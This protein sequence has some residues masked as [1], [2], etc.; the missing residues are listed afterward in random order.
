M[1]SA[2]A[3]V[4]I[5]TGAHQAARIDP[6]YFLS[7]KIAARNGFISSAQDND[8]PALAN[9][10]AIARVAEHYVGAMFKEHDPDSSDE[11]DPLSCQLAIRIDTVALDRPCG[12]CGQETVS[13]SYPS[14]K[15]GFPEM[16]INEAI[17]CDACGDRYA[18]AL[19]ALRDLAGEAERYAQHVPTPKELPYNKNP[20]MVAAIDSLSWTTCP[21]CHR[22]FSTKDKDR[23]CEGIH[24]TCKQRLRLKEPSGTEA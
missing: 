4:P 9:L 19:N 5:L 18:P 11:E 1:F 15:I 7:P 14:Y 24:L 23:W 10:I 12:L 17:V 6:N 21:N 2:A 20:V 8:A 22:R 16:F 3:A 13:S